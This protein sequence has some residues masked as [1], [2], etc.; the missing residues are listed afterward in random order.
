MA[1][2]LWRSIFQI[3]K[4]VTPGTPVAATRKVYW[5]IANSRLTRERGAR[6]HRFATA[7]RD[8]VR[9]FTLGPVTAGGSIQFP[10]SADELVEIFLVG[11]KGGV[12]PTQPNPASDPNAYKW[13][14]TPGNTLDS[15]TVEW[16]DGAISWQQAGVRA[17]Q[18]RIA[19]NVR[20]QQT[21]TVTL[22]GTDL[23]QNALTGALTDRTPTFIE[24]WESK[25]YVDAFG[26]TPGTTNV[27]QTLIN[28]DVNIQNGLARKYFADNLNKA[29]A[30][31]IGELAVEATLT[32][33]ASAAQSLTEFG[34]W[35][36]ATK[37]VI[38]L[39]FGNNQVITGGTL[40][41]TVTVDI[42]G[43][44]DL[45][46]LGQTDENTRAYQL[47][48]QYVYDPTNAFGLQIVCQNDRATAFN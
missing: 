48:M 15:M 37:R 13:T 7:T 10:L 41:K 6:P 17:D 14:F 18:I 11:I 32:F 24:G 34:N 30:V 39:E 26:A 25:L 22:F 46:D 16:N 42:P 33:E 3:G 8:N 43:A 31:T 20:E 4:E 2:E 19:G 27:A 45:F 36:S 38:R 23:V 47:R 1:G 35:D 40:K 44:W 28:W 5:D 29:E 9:A 12:T 21:V